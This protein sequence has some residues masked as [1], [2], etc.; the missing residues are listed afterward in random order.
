MLSFTPQSSLLTLPLPLSLSPYCACFLSDDF[1]CVAVCVFV[2]LYMCV[3]VTCVHAT[4]FPYWC[5]RGVAVCVCWTS[6]N[7]RGAVGPE[8]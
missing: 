7:K 8:S 1:W 5:D 2:Y 4:S 3:S 6:S